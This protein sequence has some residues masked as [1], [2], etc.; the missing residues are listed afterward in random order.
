MK[1]GGDGRSDRERLEAEAEHDARMVA[2]LNELLTGEASE[3]F[4]THVPSRGPRETNAELTHSAAQADS[5]SREAHMST[6]VDCA[7]ENRDVQIDASWVRARAAE[8]DPVPIDEGAE[9]RFDRLLHG[10]ATNFAALR[11][12]V[13]SGVF[14]HGH[15]GLGADETTAFL[16]GMDAGQL[17]VDEAGFVVPNC[18]RPKQGQTPYALCCKSGDGVS[19]NLEYV[20]QLGVM[21]ELHRD[22]GWPR[23]QLRVELGEFDGSIVHEN[24]EPLIVMEAKCRRTGTDSLSQMLLRWLR[25]AQEE[26]PP[27]RGRGRNAEHKYL[28]LLR[29]TA[30]RPTIGVLL[31]ADGARWW[32]QATR[33]EG[34]RLSFFASEPV[35]WG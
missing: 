13:S 34:H 23:E 11:P 22:L 30:E 7:N 24:A 18:V 35:S 15:R 17:W 28:D 29:L 3:L 27:I 4:T 21:A 20:I 31:V 12:D 5:H 8:S 10:W 19:I 33:E 2:R 14:R 6:L 16:R 9:E 32:M 26:D 25:F 1:P